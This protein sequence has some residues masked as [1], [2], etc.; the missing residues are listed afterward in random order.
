M[1][2]GNG[3]VSSGGSLEEGV[4][5]AAAFSSPPITSTDHEVTPRASALAALEAENADAKTENG[6]LRRDLD[7][8]KAHT[9]REK[10][11]RKVL[12][13][14]VAKLQT[15]NDSVRR[16][17]KISKMSSARVAY[18]RNALEQEV[19]K[20][21]MDRS[22]LATER[23]AG[24]RLLEAAKLEIKRLEREVQ[25]LQDK[26]EETAATGLARSVFERAGFFTCHDQPKI[27]SKMDALSK[28]NLALS[29]GVAALTRKCR[30]LE[31]QLKAVHTEL[32]ALKNENARLEEESRGHAA[33]VVEL[34]ATTEA[35]TAANVDAQLVVAA[36]NADKSR[37]EAKSAD[38][39]AALVFKN[40]AL[41]HQLAE[42]TVKAATR[43]SDTRSAPTS[44]PAKRRRS[45]ECIASLPALTNPRPRRL[46]AR[47][48][49]IM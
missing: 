24:K 47:K 8:A 38:Q 27:N 2:S 45:I 23:W 39:I 10:H 32:A 15:E 30:A 34:T 49:L 19:T 21:S 36:V 31:A 18:E 42:R 48:R 17:L 28:D 14:K 41:K 20:L 46:A 26:A 29:N 25:A 35:L 33:R 9:V 12:H 40:V 22:R 43:A 37:L 7:T 44:P 1:P 4:S 16:E 11:E 5:S 3:D 6:V 13:E